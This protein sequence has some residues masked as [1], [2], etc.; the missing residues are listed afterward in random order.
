MKS[1]LVVFVVIILLALGVAL[2][3]QRAAAASP[4]IGSQSDGWLVGWDNAARTATTTS[5]PILADFTG[6]D[7][8]GWCIKLRK[9]V[10]DTPEF[11]LWAQKSVVLL[12]V[13]FP[14]QKKLPAAQA[15]ENDNLAKKYAIEGYPTILL[16]DNKGTELGRLGYQDGGPGPWIAAA[17]KLLKASGH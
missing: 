10:F 17:E 1:L 16:L 6:S 11:I 13:D 2:Y 8:C 3:L 9:E 14:Q 7:W 12:E 5:H 4:S 15:A